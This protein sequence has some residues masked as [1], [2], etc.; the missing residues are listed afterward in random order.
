MIAMRGEITNKGC[1][2]WRRAC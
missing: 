1:Y 2:C